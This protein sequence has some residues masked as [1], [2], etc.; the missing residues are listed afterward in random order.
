MAGQQGGSG[1]PPTSPLTI[2]I[3]TT[4]H[5]GSPSFT[6]PSIDPSLAN[7]HNLYR[8]GNA[9]GGSPAMAASRAPPASDDEQ[10]LL[11][12]AKEMEAAISALLHDPDLTKRQAANDWLNTYCGQPVVWT[13]VL[14]LAFPPPGAGVGGAADVRFFALN[15]LL[16]KMRSD[17]GQ[18]SPEDAAEI[19]ET[20]VRQLPAALAPGM[21][22]VVRSR[23]CIVIG[24]AAALAGPNTCY[25]LMEAVERQAEY[26]VA[27]E[28]LTALAEEALL[29][30]RAHPREVMEC[31][32]DCCP[33][34]IR[35]LERALTSSVADT[36]PPDTIAKSL[37]CL[38]RWKQAGLTLSELHREHAPLHQALLLALAS[39]HSAVQEAAVGVLSELLLEV[40]ILPGRDEAV[41][42][43][44]QGLLALRGGPHDS[45]D[46]PIVPLVAAIGTSEAGLLSSGGDMEMRLL[47]W[48]VQLT[49]GGTTAAAKAAGGAAGGAAAKGG[50]GGGGGGAG[51][52]GAGGA[53]EE[54]ERVMD[55]AAMAAE[56][57]PKVAKVPRKRRAP[58]LQSGELFTA[59]LQAVLSASTY[60]L[61]S[62]DDI[63][64]DPDD[65]LRYREGPAAEALEACYLELGAVFLDHVSMLLRSAASWQAAE[66]AL[67]AAGAA[68]GAILDRAGVGKQG[69]GGGGGR[70]GE[71]GVS[72]S[73]T[74]AARVFLS[75]LFAS[76]PGSAAVIAKDSANIPPAALVATAMHTVAAFAPFC[77]HHPPALEAGV[78]YAVAALHIPNATGK[79]AAA[80]QSLCDAAA[81]NL[82]AA[83]V[84]APLMQSCE[85]ALAAA[86]AAR[87]GAGM[88]VGDRVAVVAGLAAVA[89]MMPQQEAQPALA[90]L[91]APALNT[92][93]QLAPMQDASPYSQALLSADL[94]V[95]AAIVSTVGDKLHAA[96]LAS[97]S[98][99]AAA[100]AAAAATGVSSPGGSPAAAAGGGAATGGA[101]GSGGAEALLLPLLQGAW[102][103][104]DLVAARWADD[105]VVGAALCG[106]WGATARAV[107]GQLAPVLPQ[108]IGAAGGMF[109]RHLH[110]A[111]LKCLAD[112]VSMPRVGARASPEVQASLAAIPDKLAAAL[113]VLQETITRTDKGTKSLH[114]HSR[115]EGQQ[116]QGQGQQ[117]QGQ[118]QGRL[119]QQEQEQH[120]RALETLQAL[121]DVA[122]AFV[123][124]A[125]ELLLP[126]PT[127]LVLCQSAVAC[128]SWADSEAVEAA[129][130]FLAE[131]IV[132][133]SLLHVRQMAPEALALAATLPGSWV[134]PPGL[135]GAVDDMSRQLGGAI[136]QEVLSAVAKG[137]VGHEAEA[138]LADVL[139]A[140]CCTHP[141][142]CEA[143]IVAT[144]SGPASPCRRAEL[145]PRH[146]ELFVAAATRQPPHPRRRFHCLMSDFGKVTSALMPP[147]AFEGY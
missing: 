60:P 77:A 102:P 8:S 18:L 113:T 129:A 36:L 139:N 100:S 144:L 122:R 41:K 74:N 58:A 141:R 17:W 78:L 118:G 61:T 140:L 117:G 9:S 70:G 15:I 10:S 16:N 115:P 11:A 119:S 55:T 48:L 103:S 4:H 94:R 56:V 42:A 116:G 124:H 75:S 3:P 79:A 33:K 68:S 106:L 84:L 35:L 109:Q 32:Q 53:G 2:P 135:R 24:A 69:A 145:S 71:E 39:Q 28:L 67:F 26:G 101:G 110:A 137:A 104:F 98:S 44:I 66:V 49:T 90:R 29:R 95:I 5:G 52:G 51:E 147:E 80:L 112:I 63:G 138:A 133:Q 127:F 99:A 65:F 120:A 87:G 23:L 73:E 45:T 27:V 125:P 83:R 114:R 19:F 134:V 130:A 22:P 25:E 21:D 82:A 108:V 1:L 37:T 20:L 128:I 14:Y 142:E 111:C 132:G 64:V 146:I 7:N 121:W 40:D 89:A 57:W 47:Q 72:E 12:G 81:P 46:S 85:E 38:A 93:Q 126:S 54:E 50:G 34:V 136:V 31:L 107:G 13:V 86:A 143:A 97:E 92:V 105:A 30:A 96:A 88:D 91:A 123:A 131:T 59:V 76:L 43:T 6:S 62:L